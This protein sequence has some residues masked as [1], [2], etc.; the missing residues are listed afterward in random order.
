M[1]TTFLIWVLAN[2]AAGAIWTAVAFVLAR[3]KKFMKWT[4]DLYIKWIEGYTKKL[5]EIFD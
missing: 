3:S 5:E 1:F 2:M 4:V